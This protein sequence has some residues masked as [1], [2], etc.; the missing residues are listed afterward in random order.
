MEAENFSP[1]RGNGMEL[2]GIF[3]T[4]KTPRFVRAAIGG[5]RIKHHPNYDKSPA[6]A[7]SRAG[8]LVRGSARTCHMMGQGE[9]DG[10]E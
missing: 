4:L 10:K 9:R 6:E 1:R 7:S 3:E 2:A 8:R 5:V